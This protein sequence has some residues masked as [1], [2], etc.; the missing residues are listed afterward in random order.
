MTFVKSIDSVEQGRSS[1][2][3]SDNDHGGRK[4]A[5]SKVRFH[6]QGKEPGYRC[7]H[8]ESI[9]TFAFLF[10]P[11]PVRRV[12]IPNRYT[13][14]AKFCFCKNNKRRIIIMETY[15]GP[16]WRLMSTRCVQPQVPNL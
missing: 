10:N 1:N 16:A 6:T 9:I 3:M 13:A 2:Q 14:K 4:S 12:Q 11:S 8:G 15:D 7:G 5:S